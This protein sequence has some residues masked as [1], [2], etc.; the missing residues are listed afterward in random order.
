MIMIAA[1]LAVLGAMVGSAAGALAWRLRHKQSWTSGRSK[2]E[3]CRRTLQPRDLVP[4][5]GWLIL[6][7]RCRDCGKLISYQYPLLELAAAA[8]FAWSYLAWPQALHGAG[9]V[10]LVI[11]LLAAAGLLALTFYDLRWQVLPNK[12]IYP[13]LLIAVVGRLATIGFYEPGKATAIFKWAAAVAI[14]SGFFGLLFLVNKK[15]IG[16]GDVRL[17]LITGTLL[18]RPG[19]AALMIFLAS[20]LGTLVSLP[21]VAAGRR[22]LASRVPFGPFLIAATFVCLLYGQSLINWYR[23]LLAG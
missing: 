10:N 11:W 16:F 13:M 21:L 20:L 7:G 23:S 1:L 3:H 4:I 2:C 18:G 15:W 6:R 9:L 5:F 8:A 12:I 17:G 14:A 19:L 22:R